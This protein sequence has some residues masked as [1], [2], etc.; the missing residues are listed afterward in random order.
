MTSNLKQLDHDR[1][2]LLAGI[3]PT[4]CATPL[5]RLRLGI[6]M[7]GEAGDCGLK[8]GIIQDIEDMDTI[9]NQFLDFAREGR[10]RAVTQRRGSQ[11]DRLQRVRAIRTHGKSVNTNLGA[12]PPQ[13]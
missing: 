5:S 4:I 3:S 13:R 2:V 8:D 10:Q 9:I 11:P 12:C 7:L 1:A 6:E